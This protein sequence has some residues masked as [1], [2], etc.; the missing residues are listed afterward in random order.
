MPV[1]YING[2]IYK[3]T[4]KQTDKIYIGSTAQYDIENRFAC[5]KSMFK[6]WSNTIGCPYVSSFEILKYGDAKITI[7]ENYPC[8]T[9]QQL[10]AREDYHISNSTEPYVNKQ[11]TF[12]GIVFVNSLDYQRKYQKKYK[13]KI[14]NYWCN[15]YKEDENRKKQYERLKQ[16]YIC[17][18]CNKQIRYGSSTNHNRSKTHIDN[19]KLYNDLLKIEV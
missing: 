17:S 10:R 8:S 14:K 3:I 2:K 6:K 4:S 15:Y 19:S 16:P 9:R 1:N 7:I 13:Q 18:H 5:H 12:T 11:T